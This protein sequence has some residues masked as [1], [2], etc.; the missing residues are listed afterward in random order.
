MG[1]LNMTAIDSAAREFKKEFAWWLDNQW[2]VTGNPPPHTNRMRPAED[3]AE[4]AFAILRRH[5]A[6]AEGGEQRPGYDPCPELRRGCLDLE[7]RLSRWESD[8][9]AK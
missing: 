9:L 1:L 3:I 4:Q 2:Q 5:F 7:Q 8:P 6:P